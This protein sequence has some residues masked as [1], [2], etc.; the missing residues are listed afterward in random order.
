MDYQRAQLEI[1]NHAIQP[2]QTPQLF[3]YKSVFLS[4]VNTT[5]QKRDQFFL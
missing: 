4:Q 3:L 5:Y 2:Y 1:A